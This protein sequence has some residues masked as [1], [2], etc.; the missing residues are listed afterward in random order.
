MLCSRFS[1]VIYFI[2]GGGGLVTESCPTLLRP[3][4]LYSMSLLCPWGFPVKNTEVGCHFLL[5]G[6]F[7]T[8]GSNLC[9]LHWQVG[10]LLLSHQGSHSQEE[11]LSNSDIWLGRGPPGAGMVIYHCLVISNTDSGSVESVNFI[12]CNMNF[13]C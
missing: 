7:L 3:H 12:Q 6:I 8:Q 9:L 1:L 2:H 10:S 5:Q 4:G 11:V 13:N